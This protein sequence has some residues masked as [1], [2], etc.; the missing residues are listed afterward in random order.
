MGYKLGDKIK[1]WEENIKTKKI[2]V[3]K[4][5]KIKVEKINKETGELTEIKNVLILNKKNKIKIGKPKLNY[6]ITAK[7]LD[8]G[9]EKKINIIKF[10]RRKNSIK[11]IGHRQYFTIIKIEKLTKKKEKKGPKKKKKKKKKS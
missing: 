4:N 9:K 11:K 10:K 8:H 6:K 3:N 7:I 5:S 1:N 2:K